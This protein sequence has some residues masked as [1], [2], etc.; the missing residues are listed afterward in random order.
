MNPRQERYVR[1]ES[2]FREVNERIADVNE[3]LAVE[4]QTEFLC[5]CGR[6]EC[7]E[8]VRLSRQEYERVRGEGDRFVVKP[9]H[10]VPAV[11]QVLERHPGF[12]LV[13]KTGGAGEESEARDP[14]G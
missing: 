1:N 10:E 7:L 5:E 4:E 9:G 13:T 8:T 12:L 3:D 2:L 14:R 6:E 11:E